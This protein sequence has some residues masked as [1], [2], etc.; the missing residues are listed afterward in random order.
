MILGVQ[1]I[2]NAYTFTVNATNGT[3]P[4]KRI[5]FPDVSAVRGKLITGFIVYDDNSIALSPNG[6]ANIPAGDSGSVFVSLVDRDAKVFVD[7]VPF[8]FYNLL[9]FGQPLRNIT[10]ARIL[11]VQKC[12]FQT[13][14]T[15][16][17]ESIV[18]TFI[19][20]DV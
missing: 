13:S 20:Q 10:P 7:N 3:G 18:C 11:D 9:R 4:G 15:F 6:T 17:L 19:Y 5:Y 14:D 1:S 12:Y 8:N 16:T 2:Y